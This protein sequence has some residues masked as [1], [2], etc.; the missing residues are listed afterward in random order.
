VIG[1]PSTQHLE[2]VRFDA[3]LYRQMIDHLSSVRPD[4][5]C[6]L[7]AF[8]GNRPVKLFPGTNVHPRPADHYRMDDNQVVD[9][10]NE[11]DRQGWWLGAIYHSHPQSDPTP[12]TTDLREANW[13][14]ALMIIVSLGST[15]P[16]VK[17]YRVSDGSPQEVRLEV[18]PERASW[19][20][21]LRERVAGSL[22]PISL[23]GLPRVAAMSN[24]TMAAS[25]SEQVTGDAPRPP[26]SHL[27]RRATIGILGG[28]GPLATSDLYTK[29]IQAT[30]ASSDQEHIPVVIY[31]DPRVPDRTQALTGR[32]DDPT[33]WLIHG[34][35]QLERM[36]V[37][38]IVIPCNTAHAFL[39]D[40]QPEVRTPILSMIDAAADE[41]ANRYPDAQVV[42]LLATSGTINSEIYQRALLARGLDTIVPDS[43]LQRSCVMGAINE[44]KAG[45]VD[46]S[47]TDLLVRAGESLVDRGAQVLLAACTEIPVVLQQRHTNVPLVDATGSLAHLAVST[48]RHLEEMD[49]AGS[50]QWETST[51]GWDSQ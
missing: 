46:R 16:K 11:M 47:A 17:A 3:R 2:P 7:I 21:G 51:I 30:P 34:A 50:P 39:P 18:L 27:P 6:G 42:G 41:I 20:H 44:V 49:R 36:E 19:I 38:F 31:A 37:D 4:E 23:G 13:P 9:A 29:I 48:A 33:P 8:H 35:R 12:S 5:G 26:M 40:V 14:D 10:I 45:R 25:G 1:T 22:A 28:M 32:G 24:G 43:S 15:V